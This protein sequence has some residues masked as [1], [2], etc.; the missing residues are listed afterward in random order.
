MARRAEDVRVPAGKVLVSE[1][2]TGHEFFVILERHR[3]GDPPGQKIA[4]LGPGRRVRRARPARQGAPQRDRRRRHRHGA[5]RARP[6]RVRGPIDEVPGFARSCSP[7]WPSRLREADASQRAVTSRSTVRVRRPSSSGR[8]P[9]ATGRFRRV[10]PESP[11]AV[12]SRIS[13]SSPSACFA[14]VFTLASGVLPA[15]THWHD[16]SPS[17]ASLRQRA[18]PR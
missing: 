1:G 6:A 5:R 2:E 9:R 10:R 3:H 18:R 11:C 14:A 8:V 4:T 7:A 13:S 15:I 12:R 17:S 16:D